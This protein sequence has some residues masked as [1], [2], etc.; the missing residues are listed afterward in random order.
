LIQSVLAFFGRRSMPLLVIGI[1]LGL[2]VPPLAAALRPLTGVLL[3]LLTAAT[4]LRIEPRAVLA[5]VRRPARLAL[6]LF[7]TMGL[8][9]LMMAFA[10]SA[11]G[12]PPGLRE[13]LVLWASASPLISSPAL[14]F[15]LGLDAPLALVAMTVGTVLMPATL[16]P[17]ALALLGLQ[18][19]IGL[20]ELMLR[21]GIFVGGAVVAAALIRRLIG[22]ARLERAGLEVSGLAVI[23]LLLF[24]I[25]IMDGVQTT[26][27][28][29][30]EQVFLFVAAAFGATLATLVLGTLVF[31]WMG[32]RAAFT[33]ALV[34]GY[35]NMAVVWASLGAAASADVT[36]YFVM[37]QLPIYL[38][39]PLLRPVV[40][41]L[42]VTEM[43][44]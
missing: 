11:L 40:R 28:E 14:A 30:P 44:R 6:V 5:E 17:L 1:L 26:F 2:F 18:L 13:A 20:G 21:L 29:Q 34:G 12:V 7:W 32:L 22:P 24:G 36:L 19:D 42:T 27:A 35:R 25:G 23:F 43:K 41:A 39:P 16:P 15:L 9:P 38:L 31:A 8:Q 10:T 4:L 3:F 37:I 33:V